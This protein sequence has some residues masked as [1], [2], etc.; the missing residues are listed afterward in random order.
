MLWTDAQ[1][2]LFAAAAHNAKIA[3]KHGM[4][5][6]EARDMLMESSHAQ[7][8]KAS[9]KQKMAKALRGS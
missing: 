4:S 5:Q 1:L 3:K 2:R 9:G 8:S 7:R 6:G